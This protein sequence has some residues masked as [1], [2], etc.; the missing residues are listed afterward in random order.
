L[1]LDLNDGIEH[2]VAGRRRTHGGVK[3]L[4]LIL[5]ANG[6]ILIGSNRFTAMDNV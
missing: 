6:D 2:H 4:L 1:I 5:R 3:Y